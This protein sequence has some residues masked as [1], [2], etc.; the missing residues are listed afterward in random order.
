V[1]NTATVSNYAL[2][3]AGALQQRIK[4]GGAYEDLYASVNDLCTAVLAL[5]ECI[6]A[7]ASA[8]STA[9]SPSAVSISSKYTGQGFTNTSPLSTTP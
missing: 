5:A 8:L 6:N 3:I 4:Q 9:V 2:Q 1:A 7:N